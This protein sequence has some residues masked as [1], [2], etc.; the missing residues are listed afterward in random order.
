MKLKNYNVHL[1]VKPISYVIIAVSILLVPLRLMLAFFL[2]VTIHELGHYL[3]LKFFGVKIYAITIGISGIIMDTAPMS[4]LTEF[5]TVVAGPI[6]GLIPLLFYRQMP[7]VAFF[8]CLQTIYNLLPI[9]P[10]DGGRVL[11]CICSGSRV[12]IHIQRLMHYAGWIVLT[13]VVF[14]ICYLLHLGIIPIVAVFIVF[15]K[16]ISRNIPCNHF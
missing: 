3:A 12:G 14:R 7:I 9:Y 6:F 11:S 10:H 4:R 5:I 1:T 13:V 8:A 2:C 16:N 15:I